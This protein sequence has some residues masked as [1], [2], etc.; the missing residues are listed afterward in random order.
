MDSVTKTT[1]LLAQIQEATK[2]PAAPADTHT[3]GSPLR[4]LHNLYCRGLTPATACGAG[5]T[6]F[7]FNHWRLGL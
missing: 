5:D 2:K 3:V 6:R 4:P 7:M 1:F